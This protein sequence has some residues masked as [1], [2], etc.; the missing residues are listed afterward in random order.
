MNSNV[1]KRL[2]E[3]ARSNASALDRN[4]KGGILPI[5]GRQKMTPYRHYFGNVYRGMIKRQPL[6]AG[7]KRY[8]I[9]Q[10]TQDMANKAW[11]KLLGKKKLDREQN[12]YGDLREESTL[13]PSQIKETI[14]RLKL[15]VKKNQYRKGWFL[16]DREVPWHA[17]A[18]SVGQRI[19][20][21]GPSLQGN[22]YKENNR[23]NSFGVPLDRNE[24]E[25]MRRAHERRINGEKLT[26]RQKALL[27]EYFQGVQKLRL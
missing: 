24:R 23:N 22:Y 12:E 11:R 19:A 7:N 20:R 9:L 3:I 17:R 5:Y 18:V 27:M 6:P 1:R 10:K 15:H 4:T 16:S 13:T 8:E 14:N 21:K 26:K 2:L 25:M